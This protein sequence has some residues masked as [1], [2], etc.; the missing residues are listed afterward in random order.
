MMTVSR[1]NPAGAAAFA[2]VAACLALA[3]PSFAGK[4]PVTPAATDVEVAIEK[5][6]KQK[7]ATFRFLKENRD[8][9][10]EQIDRLREKPLSRRGGA[11]EIDPRFLAYRD[12]LGRVQSARDSV[13]GVSDADQRNQLFA[14]VTQLGQLENELDWMERQLGE[15]QDRLATLEKDFTG[16]QKTELVVVVSGMPA[17]EAP[18]LHAIT[19][20]FEDGGRR[21]IVLSDS[22]REALVRGGVVQVFHGFVE[23]REQV[24]ELVMVGDAWPS[25]TTGYVT[26]DPARDRRTL[27]RLDVETLAPGRGAASVRASWWLDDSVD[28]LRSIS[29][30]G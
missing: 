7:R 29:V 3:P 1:R 12:M 19:L 11:A 6:V 20:V 24:F 28:D 8:F 14:S 27:L 5:P 9:L 26:L 30:D 16:D 21:E 25:G 22:L 18:A 15:Q 13:G 2:A 23:P 4:R 10:R 17:P